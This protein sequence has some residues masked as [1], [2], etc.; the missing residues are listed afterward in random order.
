MAGIEA[1]VDLATDEQ[2]RN[3]RHAYYA[4]TSYVDHWIGRLVDTLKAAELDDNTIVIVTSDHGDM[5]GERGLWYKMNFFEWSCRVPLIMAGPGLPTGSSVKNNVSLVDIFPTLVEAA[6]GTNETPNLDG[7]SLWGL[8]TGVVDPAD[9]PDEAI[10]E[11]CAE[12]ASHPC[13]MIRRGPYKYVHCD[14]DPPLLFNLEDDPNELNNLA[15]DPGH[16]NV[17]KA[18]AEE[19]RKRWDSE[20]IRED[21]IATQKQAARRL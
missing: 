4:N 8:A 11:Y 12:C 13:F 5:L 14:V 3:A 1:D 9:D 18:F 16:D 20:A 6:G 17:A 15:T 10:A 7:R 21:V 2:I 19:V